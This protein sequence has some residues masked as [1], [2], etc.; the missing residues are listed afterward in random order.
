MVSVSPAPNPQP[1]LQEV[2]PSLA[3]SAAE[4]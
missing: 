4:S 2:M 1:T 3:G